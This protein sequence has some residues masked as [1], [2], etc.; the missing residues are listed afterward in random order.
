MSNWNQDSIMEL[1][2]GSKCVEHGENWLAFYVAIFDTVRHKTTKYKPFSRKEDEFIIT[3]INNVNPYIISVKLD[4]TE[5]S[6]SKRIEKL[7][8]EGRING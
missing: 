5:R 3:N 1:I 4:R 2:R 8:K 6:V 7:K